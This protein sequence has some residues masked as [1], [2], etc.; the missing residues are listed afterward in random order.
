MTDG[1]AIVTVNELTP[2]SVTDARAQ[3]ET[4]VRFSKDILKEKIDYGRIPGTDKPTLFKPGAEKLCVF[5]RLTSE[6]VILD[7]IVDFEGGIFYFQYQCRLSTRNGTL[8]AT[9]NGSCNSRE[10]KY[11]YRTAE[12]VCPECGQPAIIKSKAEYGGGWYCFPKKGGCGAKFGPGNSAI[13]EQEIG[14]IENPDPADLLNTIDKM[15]QKRALVAAT[16]IATGASEFYTQ[17]LDD[18]IIE[19]DFEETK[20]GSTA[21]TGRASSNNGDNWINKRG[22]VILAL[23]SVGVTGQHAINKLKKLAR[24]GRIDNS[25]DDDTIIAI[26]TG[27]QKPS[28]L[29]VALGDEWQPLLVAV[30]NSNMGAGAE[31]ISAMLADEQVTLASDMEIHEQIQAVHEYVRR[32]ADTGAEEEQ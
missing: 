24:E 20:Q 17:D 18:L 2:M 11:R 8:I 9:G 23:K 28:T 29:D 25:M 15:A 16:L 12:R 19:G 7:K 32:N 21:V 27:T 4:F 6:F 3:Y 5:F 13:T 1:T 30:A 22:A 10:S 31:T 14:R 26:A